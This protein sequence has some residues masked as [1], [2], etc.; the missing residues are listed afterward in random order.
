MALLRA[1]PLK[2]FRTNALST[3][4]AGT[5][6]ST[7]APV[8]G[9]SFYGGLH[10]TCATLGTTARM[11]VMLI[12]SASSSGFGAPTTRAT[13]AL[14]TGV[15][16]EWATPVASPSTD[17]PWWRASWTLSTAVSTGG[18]WKGLVWMG[19]R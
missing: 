9:Q 10:L 5:A 2:D 12:Q 13:F 1:V 7:V 16:A 11:L 14:S 19:L 17:Q 6:F 3:T 15:G 8:A 4:A 18:T